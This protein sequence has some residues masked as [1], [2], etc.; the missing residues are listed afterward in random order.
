MIPSKRALK[1]IALS[2]L[3]SG[4]GV[5][6]LYGETGKVMLLLADTRLSPE[7]LIAVVGDALRPL[8][9]SGQPVRAP[10][11]QPAWY[12]DYEFRK[13]GKFGVSPVAILIKYRDLS[14]TLSDYDRATEASEFDRRVTAAIQSGLRAQL[15]ADIKFAH[16]GTPAF[17]LGP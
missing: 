7:R 1:I 8:G 4:C 12:W 11:P 14:I 10:T 13:P 15:G 17:C 6:C 16:P 3:L 9:F 2:G 5:G